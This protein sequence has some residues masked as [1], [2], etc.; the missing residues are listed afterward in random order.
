[1]FYYLNN[2]HDCYK[3]AQVSDARAQVCFSQA[4]VSRVASYA[5]M[6]N[7]PAAV[8]HWG[9]SAWGSLRDTPTPRATV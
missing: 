3:W 2:A 9:A 5:A 1:M 4:G 6:W 8:S 7:N